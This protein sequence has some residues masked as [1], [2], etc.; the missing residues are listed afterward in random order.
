[1]EDVH[2]AG[3]KVFMRVHVP[4]SAAVFTLFWMPGRLSYEPT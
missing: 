1:M 4:V 2:L 3:C